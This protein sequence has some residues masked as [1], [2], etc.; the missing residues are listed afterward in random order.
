MKLILEA[1][2]PDEQVTAELQALYPQWDFS[3]VEYY[4]DDGSLSPN[5]KGQRYLNNLYCPIK[6][7]KTGIPHGVSD[8][9]K[10]AYLYK[11]EGGCRECRRLSMG[12]KRVDFDEYVKNFPKDK[13][14][15]FDQSNFYRETR[16]NTTRRHVKDVFC[17]KKDENGNT[18]GLFA[19]DG[20][21]I[22]NLRKGTTGCPKC[23]TEEGSVG[24][25][26]LYDILVQQGYKPDID[27]ETEKKFLDCKSGK[28]S[29][30]CT[31]LKFDFYLKNKGILVEYDGEQHFKPN[32]KHGGE[33]KFRERVINDGIKNRYTS[34]NNIKLIRI[35]YTDFTD[36]D[37]LEK[38]LLAGLA[39]PNQL[40][41]SSTY[42]PLGWNDPKLV[43]TQSSESKSKK[44]YII[45][46]SQ[47]KAIVESKS[48]FIEKLRRRFNVESMRD[49]I[50]HAETEF[51]DPC[52]KFDN[53]FEFADS[54]I[55]AAVTEFL[56]QEELQDYFHSGDWSVIE[57][58]HL[59]I[60]MC[61]DWFGDGLMGYYQTTCQDEYDDEDFD[62]MSEEYEIAPDKIIV[63][64]FRL[65]NEYKKSSKTKK[66][67]LNT[68]MEFLPMF[69][70]S[71]VYATY[72]L[73]LYLLNYREDGDYSGLNKNNFIDPRNKSGKKTANYQ[74]GDYTKAQLPFQGS[75]LRGY[76][77]KD[78]N[79][80]KYYVVKSYGWYPVYIYK[81]GKWYENFDRYSN[82]T[83]KQMLR[84]RP[85]TYNSDID[86]NVYLMS[87]KEMEMLESGFSH[88]DVMKKKKESLKDVQPSPR[89]TTA[90][91]EYWRGDI[92]S[93][94]IKFKISSIEDLGD[95]NAVNVDIYDV[96]KTENGKQIPTPENYLKGELGNV[97]P[98]KVEKE[99]E[100]KL[101]QNFR[102]YLGPKLGN[103]DEELVTFRF[104]HLKK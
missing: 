65:F 101:R 39:S 54:I 14:Y 102:Q 83:S 38:E 17:T 31:R 26:T 56:F 9:L 77:T 66:E 60:T 29:N 22:D 44:E 100:K 4:F 40:Y 86:T 48:V 80:V 87:K 21:N 42:P 27:F 41:L 19:K 93:L 72:M 28:E 64:L 67:L 94:N 63:K 45:T 1:K 75:N 6:D 30:R 91:S 103:T 7:E 20:V 97:T 50:Y 15:N 24:E 8:N 32:A 16:G 55:G 34:Q 84:S 71:K 37:K 73:E 62:V 5:M 89:I 104:N 47:L 12:P 43:Q 10:V 46:E 57:T 96:L 92:P 51:S 23:R 76:W 85:Y 25:K 58:E 69:G 79:G 88:E 49:Y 18:H 99:V 52:S 2:K 59:M 98:E 74:A 35:A 70:I 95:K 36:S 53:E 61:K 13:G 81:E 82:S 3:K 78:R 11:G 90:K 68:I 33:E